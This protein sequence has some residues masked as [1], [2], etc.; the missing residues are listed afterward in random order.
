[1]IRTAFILLS[2]FLFGPVV[3]A[4]NQSLNA[5][6][7]AI[8]QV[9][10]NESKYF[11]GRDLK[12]WK[13]TY[14]HE[15]YVSWTSSSREGV[16][17]YEGWKTWLTEVRALFEESPE[18][19]PYNENVRKYN[20]VFRIYGDGAWVSFEQENNGVKTIET[21]ILEKQ[22]GGW[23]IAMV[24]L[25]FNANEDLEENENDASDF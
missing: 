11:W 16:T 9:I 5:E 12:S 4:Q 25:L 17:R 23:K 6:E 20:Y 3:F 22:N 7:K 1:M 14:V 15:P 24:Q 21:R 10:E 8:K 18:P 19:I 13:K 2:F